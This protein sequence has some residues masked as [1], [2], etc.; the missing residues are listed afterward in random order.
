[1]INN[2]YYIISYYCYTYLE[3]F[4]IFYKDHFNFCNKIG[5]KGRI[6]ISQ[7]GINGTISGYGESCKKYIKILLSDKRFNKTD[8]KIHLSKFIPFPRLTI[9][10]KNENIN[11]G[12]INNSINIKNI[13]TNKYVNYKY[14][15]DLIDDDK[16]IF[17][18]VRS[19]YEFILGHFKNAISLNINYFREFAKKMHNI[20]QFKNNKIITYCTGGIRCEKAS[21][22]MLKNGFKNVYQLE[23]GIIKYGL[24][25]PGK[26]FIG[27]CYVFDGRISIN[28]NTVNP[29]VI[30][31]CSFCNKKSDRM[32]N[33]A[34]AKCNKHIIQCIQC[35]HLLNGCC[36]DNCN[37]C[38]DKRIYNGTGIYYRT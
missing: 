30:S 35:S 29:I 18:D 8:F 1:M 20:N 33:C 37:N 24:N 21:L 32:I 31:N 17:L 26:N 4:M 13:V 22:Y 3:N 12:I 2:Q 5:L 10:C 25:T 19:H 6:I 15:D 9:K 38:E 7:E 36:S 14:I 28:I 23:G 11:S 27:K 34:N 16:V